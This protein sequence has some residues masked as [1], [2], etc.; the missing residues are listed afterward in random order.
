VVIPAAAGLQVAKSFKQAIAFSGSISIISVVLGLMLAFQL[1]LP[2]SGS[3][4]LISFLMFGI[5]F[6]FSRARG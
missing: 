2:A 4:V 6:G 1:D 5:M 3:I